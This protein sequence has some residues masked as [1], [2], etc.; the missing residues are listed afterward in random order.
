MPSITTVISFPGALL[1]ATRVRRPD[2][3]RLR[4]G[5]LL[6]Y[7]GMALSGFASIGF[8]A[9]ANTLVQLTSTAAMRGR[10]VGAWTMMLP[11]LSPITA[12]LLALHV[13]ATGPRI[14]F[15]T[16]GLVIAVAGA[17]PIR[18]EVRLRCEER[19]R[20]IHAHVIV[21]IAD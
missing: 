10:I 7:A 2:G 13:D 5:A 8:I 20:R 4:A 16:K 6:A 19:A 12:I 14:A 21:S 1:S 3:D 11:A 15:A 18:P 17:G 9:A